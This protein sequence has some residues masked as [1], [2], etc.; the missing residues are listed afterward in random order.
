MHSLFQ[1]T[2]YILLFLYRNMINL[3][4][5]LKDI[6]S[7]LYQ[8]EEGSAYPSLLLRISSLINNRVS[9][10]GVTSA[11]CMLRVLQL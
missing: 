5:L 7:C 3:C 10:S 2:Y 8:Q 6:L 11:L 1:N 9:N 4:L